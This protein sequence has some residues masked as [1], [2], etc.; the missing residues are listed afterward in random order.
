[1]HLDLNLKQISYSSS[2]ISTYTQ[3]SYH[4]QYILKLIFKQIKLTKIYVCLTEWQVQKT[5][6]F[7]LYSWKLPNSSRPLKFG[8]DKKTK[9]YSYT[10]AV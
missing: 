2:E 9:Q 4:L 8:I 1:M 7:L 5:V 6:H 10:A 3:S